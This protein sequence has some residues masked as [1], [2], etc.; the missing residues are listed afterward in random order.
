M[1]TL[2]LCQCNPLVCIFLLFFVTFSE[3]CVSESQTLMPTA[4]CDVHTRTSWTIPQTRFRT[5]NPH[6]YLYQTCAPWLRTGELR[7]ALSGITFTG[8]QQ[9]SNLSRRG[10]LLFRR[11]R[12]PLASEGKTRRTVIHR[13]D[14]RQTCETPLICL[15]RRE[16]AA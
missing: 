10:A 3:G 5:L 9:S 1:T 4:V 7:R 8:T 6:N 14:C 11:S 16:K 13:W 15:P 2:R 12:V